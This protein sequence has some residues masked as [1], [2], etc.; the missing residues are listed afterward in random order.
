MIGLNLPIVLSTFLHH[1]SP[2]GVR[3]MDWPI[4]F[5]KFSIIIKYTIWDQYPLIFFPSRLAF[6]HTTI[7]PHS[8]SHS[9]IEIISLFY[10][11]N[12][13]LRSMKFRPC[14]YKPAPSVVSSN[15]E[16]IVI[17]VVVA[18]NVV[19][20][21]HS[22]L[23]FSRSLVC[24]QHFLFHSYYCTVNWTT[25]TRLDVCIVYVQK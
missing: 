10:L 9:K 25:L 22:N 16:A 19:D 24:F 14:G 18:V 23:Y 1:S 17:F 4:P 2:S 13:Y 20:E 5:S 7:A 11:Y 8:V 6:T 21:Y 12:I 15:S 3:L